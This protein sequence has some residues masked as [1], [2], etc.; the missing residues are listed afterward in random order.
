M[1]L[2]AEHRSQENSRVRKVRSNTRSKS[3][4]RIII[5]E[6]IW[7]LREENAKIR[8]ELKKISKQLSSFIEKQIKLSKQPKSSYEH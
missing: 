6:D 2:S 7:P 8:E 5:N 1:I 4:K 3:K